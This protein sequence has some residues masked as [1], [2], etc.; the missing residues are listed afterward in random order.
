MFALPGIAA[1][2]LFVFARPHEIYRIFAGIPAM[3]L[4][5]ALCALG[6]A[7]DVRLRLS[8]PR[9][10]SQS[11]LAALFLVW[12]AIA[13]GI[14][15]PGALVTQ[16]VASVPPLIVY[17]ALAQG[18]QT[19]RGL[20][21]IA[22]ALLVVLLVLAVVCIEQSRS[23]FQCVRLAVDG[24]RGDTVGYPDGR[25]CD[26]DFN[27]H[28]EGMPG[29]DY[30]CEKPGPVGTTSVG[31]GRVRYRGVLQDPNEFALAV[32]MALPLALAF[33]DRRRSLLRL[34]LLLLTV[35][36][37]LFVVVQTRSRTGQLVLLGTVAFYFISAIGWKGVVTAAV[38]AGP[39]L[40]LGGR[41]GE[42]ADASAA[43][44]PEAWRAG[45]QMWMDSPVWGVGRRQFL[46]HHYITAHNTFV[47][48][49]AELGFVGLVVWI[50]LWWTSFKI[51]HAGL[52]RLRH[53]PE[54][55]PA[56]IW[57]RALLA[58]LGGALAACGFLSLSTHP[59]V[60]TVF[61]LTGAYYLA[62]RHHDP[63]FRVRFGWRDAAGVLVLAVLFLGLLVGY[64][65]VTGH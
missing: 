53:R 31:F 62:I 29:Q 49:L 10:T 17:F 26:A 51:V 15:A 22:A 32:G 37:V 33:F 7:I 43:E 46:E 1:L 14:G 48:E 60:W 20:E 35:A 18:A 59:V 41:G 21:R 28:T 38:V 11:V 40:L 13:T 2:V 34:L 5:Y 63:E 25:L 58:M 36:L 12:T 61:G 19:L 30:I 56:V 55:A 6:V 65:R 42:E 54:A 57:G 24:P 23:P 8:W 27:C 3:Y 50:A 9:L 47:L 52:T 39:V 4:L 45:L 64:L 44:R 16:T